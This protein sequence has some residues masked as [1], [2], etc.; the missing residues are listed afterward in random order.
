M[1]SDATLKLTVQ[2]ALSLS[3]GIYFEFLGTILACIKTGIFLKK[4]TW[5]RCRII[6][7]YVCLRSRKIFQRKTVIGRIWNRTDREFN[8]C[9]INLQNKMLLPSLTMASVNT[10]NI[11]DL[12]V[13]QLH[14]RD[15]CLYCWVIMK[16]NPKAF[17]MMLFCLLGYQQNS[18]GTPSKWSPVVTQ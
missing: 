14:P 17:Q 7:W 8:F 9:G 18:G 15:S 12:C 16:Y 13:S 10:P 3:W 2:N 1:T 4:K 6:F 11:C 5:K